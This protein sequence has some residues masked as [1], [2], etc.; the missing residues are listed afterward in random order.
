MRSTLVEQLQRSALRF[1]PRIAL[2]TESGRLTY[3]ELHERC[4]RC[5]RVLTAL[6]LRPSERVT[7]YGPNG[8]D[9][10]VSYQG[11][12]LSGAIV[13]PINVLLTAE[14]VSFIVRDCGSRVVIGSREKLE[15]LRALTS[16]GTLKSLVCFGNDSPAGMVS[17]GDLL[18]SADMR[19]MEAAL[20]PA[21]AATICY[22]SGT[23]G[24]PKGAVQSHSN[25]LMNALLTALMHGRCA[26]DIVVSAL[27]LPHVYGTVVMNSTLLSGGTLV[28]HARFEERAI[29]ASIA[30]H[31]AT[32]LE[33]VP[34]MYYYLLNCAPLSNYELS[35]L[36]LC[37]VGGQTMPVAAMERVEQEFGCPLIELWGMTEL[38]GL[39]T[40]F[41]YNGPRRLGSIG[42]PLPYCQAKVVDLTD[43]SKTLPAGETGELML[44]GP[45]VMQGYYRREQET[46]E[47]I[48][49]DGWLHTGDIARIDSD[50]FI[51]IVDRKK[52]L[53]VTGG[54]KV[55]PAEIERAL[56]AHP[57]VA[58]VAVAG[59]ADAA[60]GEVPKAYVVLRSGVAAESEDL[61]R[62]CR[63]HLAPYKV[64][65]SVQFVTE[66]PTT[67]TGKVMRRRLKELELTAFAAV[68]DGSRPQTPPSRS[69]SPS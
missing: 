2:E 1:G 45:V 16:D 56:A 26:T 21:A 47:A 14:E 62:F 20:D 4:S 55:Y 7:I 57:A 61:V 58:M 44:H 34:T 65:R 27:P 68:P 42:A 25:L 32:I 29:L 10:V 30:A 66:L 33:G 46:R 54:Y 50:G 12:L 36:R 17:L 60:K 49:P 48:E 37:T 59:V 23:T 18:A 19:P 24:Q 13:N 69:R 40:T 31:R 53:I 3:A 51:Y 6:G 67:S 63:G 41:V 22:T 9:W 11:A 28:L 43:A 15:P 8:L 52:D 38:A 39:G 35:T 64:P 5:A